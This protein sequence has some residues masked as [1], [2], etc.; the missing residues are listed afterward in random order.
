MLNLKSF[1]YSK[2]FCKNINS[3]VDENLPILSN[4]RILRLNMNK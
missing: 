1:K 3:K 2:E 4:F